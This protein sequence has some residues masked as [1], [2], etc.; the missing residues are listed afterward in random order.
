VKWRTNLEQIFVGDM[1]KFIDP[2]DSVA[3]FG[4]GSVLEKVP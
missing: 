2:F 4:I 3:S 1:L